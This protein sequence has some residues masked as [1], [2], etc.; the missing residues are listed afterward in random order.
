MNLWNLFFRGIALTIFITLASGIYTLS[1]V[2]SDFD[3]M[4]TESIRVV[5]DT[6]HF[7]INAWATENEYHIKVLAQ[8]PKIITFTEELLATN[9]SQKA[10]LA[11]PAQKEIRD[12]LKPVLSGHELRGFFII[13]R[14]NI[15]LASTR[16]NN[17]GIS[18]LTINKA[19]FQRRVWNGDTLISSPQESDVPLKNHQ[20]IFIDHYPTMFVGTPIR[21]SEGKIIAIFTLRID[22]TIKLRDIVRSGR[23]GETGES[24]LID[25]EGYLLTNSRFDDELISQ[26]L[27]TKGESS[28]F[29]IKVNNPTSNVNNEKSSLTRMAAS[30]TKGDSG[31]DVDGYTDYRGKVV[32]GA[33]TWEPLLMFGIVTEIDSSEAFAPY[34]RTQQLFIIFTIGVMLFF[35]GFSWLFV[36]IHSRMKLNENQADTLFENAGDPILIIDKTS[37]DIIS[38][39]KLTSTLLKYSQKEL[40]GLNILSLREGSTKENILADLKEVNNKG[41]KLIQTSYCDKNGNKIP[42]EVSAKIVPYGNTEVILSIVRDVTKHKKYLAQI[43]ES[44]ARLKEAQIYAKMG[45]WELFEDHNTAVWSEQMYTL[46]GLPKEFE[47]GPEILCDVMH[48]GDF[49]SFEE[50]IKSCFTTGLE[51]HIEYR[52]TRASDGEERWIECRGKVVAQTG[53][54]LKKISGF[55][56]DITERKS[57]EEKLELSSRVF[58]D[59]HEGIIITDAKLSIIDVNPAFSQITG[60][61]CEEIIG[62]QPSILSSGKQ[63]PEFYVQMWKALK[64]HGHWHGEVWNRTKHGELYAELLTISSLTN[65]D[66]EV[67]NYVGMFSDITSSKQHQ[68]Q[69]DLMAHYDV[70]TKLPNR[71]LFI[72]RFNQSIAHSIRTGHQ[73]AVCFLDIDDFKPVND[74]FGHQAGDRLLI[75]VAKRIT[76]C[77]REEDTVSRQGGDEFAILLNDIESASHYEVT[78]ARIHQALAQP[79]FI[80]DVQH[81]ITA[82]SGVTLY[83]SDNGDID[84]LLR[85]A[86]H[87]MYKS[88]LLGKHR[89]QLYSSDSDERIIL[90]NT[91]LEEIKQAL[92]KHELQMYYQPKVNMVTGE[93]FGAEALIRWIHPEK[94]VISPLDFLPSIDGT[95]LEIT[96]GTWV[97]NQALQQLVKLQQQGVIIEVSVNI[98]SNHLLSPDFVVELE[99]SLAEHSSVKP[100]YL[101]LEILES[102]ALGDITSITEIIET[103]QN[104]LGVSFSLDDFGTGYSS[105]THLRSLPVDTIKIDQSFI[106]DMLDDPSDYSIV[107]GVLAL[108]KTFNRNVIAEGVEST[109]HGLMLLLM[110][111]E[112]AQGYSIAKP[113][114]ATDFLPWLSDYTPNEN[115]LLC[116]NKYRNNKENSLE[117]FKIISKQWKNKFSRKIESSP[118]DNRT[119]WP[120]IDSKH[121][122]CG[123]W[124]HQKKQEVLFE[125]DTLQQLEKS[126]N[127]I[128]VIAN[129]MQRNY[130]AGEIVVARNGIADLISAFE[131]MNNTIGL[132]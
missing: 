129:A 121:C 80:D 95:P 43:Q 25:S 35:G 17:T 19:E 91:K 106:R 126:H 125:E 124:I 3:I 52:I 30:V 56:Q 130:Q 63:S 75:E 115:W 98:S 51:H 16:D 24:Y 54:K 131:E 69:L 62:K 132:S 85:H 12:Y 110:G 88:K 27:L 119:L 111:C 28:S 2:K 81:N 96:I 47:A 64:E 78:M 105:L 61:T 39:N 127:K 77:I 9:H 38:A 84:T 33:W 7:A 31:I 15:N 37:G 99:K 122:H 116:G 6:T 100:E 50:S 44:E 59:T 46:F 117:M 40:S 34:N 118:D 67:T 11:H 87:A 112:Q 83:P 72:D 18:N 92:D 109:N 4:V 120:I 89:S 48:K 71:A 57:I 128:H 102:S 65:D 97:I 22:P 36:H 1:I 107:E 66:N 26:K 53:G 29:N 76:N 23:I 58:S 68:D 13:S 103:C 114:P 93:V 94:G 104:R 79:Y 8:A 82:S 14:D 108:S 10:L 113:M 42:V 49:P 60:Y 73:L 90:K 74:N 45:Y 70:L 5:R 20:G 101:Q 21:N 32:V 86:D 41:S 123:H 55:I